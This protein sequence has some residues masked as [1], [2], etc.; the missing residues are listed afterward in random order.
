M[1]LSRIFLIAALGLASCAQ[2]AADDNLTRYV[3]PR[4]GTGGHGHVFVGANMPFGLVQ[5]GPTSIPQEWDW[6]S[7][8][9]ESD[10][11]VIGFSHTHLSGTGI[12]DLFD[13]TVMPVVG[14]VTCARGTEED[15]A[16]GLWSYA[17]RTKEVAARYTDQIYDFT[18][19]GDFSAARNFSFSKATMEYIYAPDADEV[20]DA[21]NRA[22]FLDLK[23]CLLP[24]IE[25]VQM[26]YVTE[27]FNTVMNVKRELRPKLFKRLRTFTWIDPVH[28]TV[29]LDPV[30]FDSEIEILHKPLSVHGS[31]DFEICERIYARDGALSPKLRKMYAKELL[32]CGEL[33]DFERA[34]DFFTMEWEKDPMAEAGRE[35]ACVLAHLARLQGNGAELMKYAL[36]DMLDTPCA[37]I[38]YELGCYYKDSMDYDEAIV[39]YQNAV[40]ETECILDV[41]TG[42]KKSLEG[43]VACY[44]ALLAQAEKAELQTSSEQQKQSIE[45]YEQ[46]LA[47]YREA[48][49]DWQLP[50][51]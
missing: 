31:R 42:G 5:L 21:E 45:I 26:W 14:E 44:E 49:A 9:H 13:V 28:E 3:D 38:C 34:E 1:N 17:D 29:R 20:L 30:V 10:S 18:W 46:Q 12:G 40:S 35:A 23:N 32:K 43:L 19:I 48:L 37:E 41:E 8:Y 47:V 4:I 51:E 39:W 22:R 24:E 33:P 15:P 36:R 6:T 2:P 25:I 7:G 16:S 27:A 50:E 11:T